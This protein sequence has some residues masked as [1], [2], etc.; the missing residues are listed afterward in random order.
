MKCKVLDEKGRVFFSTNS[1]PRYLLNRCGGN[2]IYIISNG[3]RM[4]YERV[5][6]RMVR[7]KEGF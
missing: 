5:S 3:N 1:N 6:D 2:K 7:I 4:M